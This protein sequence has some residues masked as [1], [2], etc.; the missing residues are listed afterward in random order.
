MYCIHK[1]LVCLKFPNNQHIQTNNYFLLSSNYQQWRTN[2]LSNSLE[3]PLIS[4]TNSSTCVKSIGLY[5][6]VNKQIKRVTHHTHRSRELR[7]G[8]WKP[9]LTPLCCRCP[10][11]CGVIGSAPR[12][13]GRP[14][15]ALPRKPS[16][17]IVGPPT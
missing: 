6:Y 1:N 15:L 10:G 4:C 2:F 8:S 9:G 7:L 11:R 3:P 17:L 14:R 13:L 12:L 5:N 16:I